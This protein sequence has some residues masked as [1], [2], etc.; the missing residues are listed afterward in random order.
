MRWV[1]A[2]LAAVAALAVAGC[3]DGAEPGAPEGATLVLDFQP[4]AVHAGL[5][6]A[7]QRGFFANEGVGLE[8]REPSSTADGAKLLEA[9]RADFAI[10]DINDFGLARRRGLDLEAIA[11]V[12]QRPLA[13][14]IAADRTRISTPADLRGK[15][16]GVTGVPSDDAALDTVLAE[17]GVRPEEVERQTIGFE[18]V[19]LLAAGKVDAATAFWNAEG[20]QLRGRGIPV[21]EFRLD[22][23][24][25]PRYPELVIAT[26]PDRIPSE[27]SDGEGDR[28]VACAL[29]RGLERGYE[30]LD[31][32]P[33]AALKALTEAV[34]AVDRDSQRDQLEALRDADAFSSEP[35][36]EAS[37]ALTRP[38]LAR[39]LG[40][41]RDRGVLSPGATV[42]NGAVGGTD[43]GAPASC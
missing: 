10:L 15:T 4:N 32:N 16:V 43:P 5:Y 25:A 7:Q 39:W 19:R 3:G 1:A 31:G 37:P 35:G 27:G 8:I 26:T 9:G 42:A 23:F 22:E 13:A 29:I 41:A 18:S 17:G 36:G 24:G 12:V 28:G 20:V 2:L 30:L 14:V 21:R 11:A 38:A 34:P 33:E 40:W 6:A